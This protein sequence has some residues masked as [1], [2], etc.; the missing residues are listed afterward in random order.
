MNTA[1]SE[2]RKLDQYFTPFWVTD[3]LLEHLNLPAGQ[4]VLEPCFGR[5]HIAARLRAGKHEVTSW[6]YDS[7]SELDLSYGPGELVSYDTD[8]LG[9]DTRKSAAPAPKE[10]EF[11]WVITNPPYSLGR[12]KDAVKASDFF[13]RALD[14]APNVAMLLRLGWLENCHD[15]RDLLPRLSEILVI[16]RVQF[17]GAKGSGSNYP[18]IWCIVREGQEGYGTMEWANDASVEYWQRYHAETG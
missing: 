7:R 5:G 15:R 11:D 2:R 8:F 1:G 16:P 14:Y 9:R 18:S 6:E 13:R 17:I 10:G 12:G 3:L 4:R